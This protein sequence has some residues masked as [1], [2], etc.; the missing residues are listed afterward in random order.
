MGRV[1]AVVRN[2]SGFVE[3]FCSTEDFELCRQWLSVRVP[4]AHLH[5]PIADLRAV[6]FVEAGEATHPAPAVWLYGRCS[7]P[8]VIFILDQEKGDMRGEQEARFMALRARYGECVQL[9]TGGDLQQPPR[10]LH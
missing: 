8:S 4:T 7:A 6:R 2:C 10:R 5:V 1:R 3:V 9:A